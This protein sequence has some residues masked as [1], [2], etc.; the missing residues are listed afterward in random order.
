MKNTGYCL[1]AGSVLLALSQPHDW[2]DHIAD[3]TRPL[4]KSAGRTRNKG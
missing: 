3:K 2:D 4:A 1:S